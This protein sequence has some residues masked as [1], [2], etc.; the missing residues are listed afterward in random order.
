IST[1]LQGSILTYT[2]KISYTIKNIG[3]SPA[4]DLVGS[5]VGFE[6]NELIQK[7]HESLVTNGQ[8]NFLKRW[9]RH[10]TPVPS[11][12]SGDPFNG[13]TTVVIPPQETITNGPF[14]FMSEWRG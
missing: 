1:N 2:L 13:G 4:I 6:E 12:Y 9:D 14:M 3:Y 8:T 11:P 7:M 5:G 10:K